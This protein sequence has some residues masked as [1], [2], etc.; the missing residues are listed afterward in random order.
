MRK[1]TKNRGGFSLIEMAAVVVLLGILVGF[2]FQFLVGGIDAYLVGRDYTNI[3]QEGKIALERMA[4]E[5]R[6]ALQSE[7]TIGTSSIT[8]TKFTGSPNDPGDEITFV[9]SPGSS[10]LKRESNGADTC[11]LADNVQD[12]SPSFDTAYFLVTLDLTLARGEGSVRY[13]TAVHPRN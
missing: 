4:R 10:S 9:V 2:S 7:I 13:R 11:D 3:S 12:F 5:V 6:F 8:F 1:Q